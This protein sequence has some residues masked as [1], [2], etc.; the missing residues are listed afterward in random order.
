MTERFRCCSSSA[1]RCSRKGPAG[2]H[3]AQVP[4]HKDASYR[5]PVRAW[6]EVMD[7][8][9][10]NSG[11]LRLQRETL[12]GLLRFKA[13]RA[14]TTFDEVVGVLLAQAGEVVQ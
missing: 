11:W 7:L 8:Y 10:P 9:F 6:R 14:L 4:W 2:L 13:R 5:L 3:V 12:D 1:A